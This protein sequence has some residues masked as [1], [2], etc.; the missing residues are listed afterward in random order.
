LGTLGR[1]EYVGREEEWA[2]GGERHDWG[3]LLALGEFCSLSIA[4]SSSRERRQ[5]KRHEWD[6]KTETN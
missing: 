1:P 4:S 5:V 3:D 6:W 2:K